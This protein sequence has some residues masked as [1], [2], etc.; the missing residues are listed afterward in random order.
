MSTEPA[1][2]VTPLDRH[3]PPTVETRTRSG[4]AMAALIVGI[5]AV[6][7]ILIPIAGVVLGIVAVVLGATARSDIGRTGQSGH[8]QATAGLILGCVALAGS[9]AFVIVAALAAS[10]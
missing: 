9:V 7:G 8:G 3:T 4:R 6:L 1:P 10:S 5:I 2:S